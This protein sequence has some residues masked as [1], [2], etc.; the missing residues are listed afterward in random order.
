MTET[1]ELPKFDL[2]P[3]QLK[4]A[5]KIMEW[6][7]DG[8]LNSDRPIFRLF[9]YAG[10]GKTTT[11]RKII[12]MLDLRMGT[13]VLFAA[14]TGKA[15]LVMRRHQL[16][17][18]TIHSLIYKPVDPDKKK[19]NELFNALKECEDADEKK[20]IRKELKEAQQVT[21]HLR[22]DDETPLSTARLLVLDECSMVNDD[23]LRDLM[24]YQVPMLVLGDPGQL[25][26]I[27][28]EGALTK[29]QPD[30]MLTEIHR[31]A[32]GNPIIDYATRARNGV[33]IP[34]MRM[35]S[36][37]HVGKETIT[38]EQIKSFDQIMTGKNTT[39]QMLNQ[40]IRAL[41][42]RE[43]SPYP[44]VGEKLIC[45]RNDAGKGLFNGMICE[46][47]GVGDL[48]D[49]SIELKIKRED[50]Y[51]QQPP[52]E[53]KALRAHFD[54]YHDKEAL[55]NVKWWERADSEEFDFGYAITV[56]KSQG[57]QWDKVLL[58]DD[59]FFNWGA[60][61]RSNRRRWLYTGITRAVESITIAS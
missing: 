8:E 6:Y 38:N 36:S 20:R 29:E 5:N 17:A 40:K 57:S 4:A 56:H 22:E 31:Q 59:N 45:L 9:G 35:G 53:V 54:A 44:V 21:F 7:N 10:T 50:D 37:A 26:P 55:D 52:L 2:A 13:D 46:V 15:A 11:I 43:H 30:A 39:R 49:A 1:K 24:E 58:W 12:E 60:T 14:F 42:G 28:G 47:V 19:C 23:M 34:K 48:L 3:Q 27:D 25:P 61:H 51:E 32:L 33:F 16:P 41:Y 18:S